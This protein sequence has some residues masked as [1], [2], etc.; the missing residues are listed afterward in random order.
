MF[1]I[2]DSIYL[3]KNFKCIFR[4]TAKKNEPVMSYFID[5]NPINYA[6]GI[7][8]STQKSS[9]NIKK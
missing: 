5:V 4:S 2:Y 7:T 6:N 9:L 1:S 8:M 3:K